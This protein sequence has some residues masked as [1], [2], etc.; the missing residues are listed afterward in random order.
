MVGGGEGGAAGRLP[1]TLTPGQLNPFT[2]AIHI[3]NMLTKLKVSVL[4]H[5][6]V[7]GSTNIK[8]F[9]KCPVV[10]LTIL[11]LLAHLS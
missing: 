1:Q 3:T 7:K 11:L 5:K 2:P 8:A 4:R 6:G 10:I 9:L